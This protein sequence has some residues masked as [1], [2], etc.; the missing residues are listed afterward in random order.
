M[1]IPNEARAEAEAEGED[2]SGMPSYETVLFR[3]WDP[4]VLGS[5]LPLLEAPQQARFLGAATGLA[6]DAAEHA[7]FI[8]L[9]RSAGLPA[10]QTGLLRFTTEQMAKLQL[11]RS[12]ASRARI[13]AYLRDVAAQRTSGMG[14][15]ELDAWIR[16]AQ[17]SGRA[18]H[19][20]TERAQ[21]LWAYLEIASNGQ[22]GQSTA[23][24][25]CLLQNGGQEEAAFF[26]LA[27]ATAQ[28]AMRGT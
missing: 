6:F 23:I 16:R 24:R 7:G 15:A 4:N 5:L 8:A 25:E 20:R 1:Q 26:A 17:A 11:V 12:N 19:L 14:D 10:P 9:A 13:A 18:I 21:A 27:E 3:H 28:N 2:V 22:V